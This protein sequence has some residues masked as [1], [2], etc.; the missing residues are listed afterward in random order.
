MKTGER[1]TPIPDFIMRRRDLTHGAKCLWG[2]LDR[3]AQKNGKCY[4]SLPTLATELGTSIDSV[5]RFIVQL[6]NAGLIRVAKA[7]LGR[8]NSTN[9]VLCDTPER[10]AETPPF[11][12]PGKGGRN[13]TFSRSEK[14][15]KSAT[16]K[17]ARVRLEKVANSPSKETIVGRK[18]QEKRQVEPNVKTNGNYQATVADAEALR[19]LMFEHTRKTETVETA[20][21]WLRPARRADGWADVK[22]QLRSKLTSHKPRSNAWFRTVL[23][24]EFGLSPDDRAS[25]IL[26]FTQR[27]REAVKLKD[28]Q[29]RNLEAQRCI[30]EA[31]AHGITHTALGFRW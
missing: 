24:N 11:E 23:A 8:G 31:Q 26:G 29:E 21:S 19:R 25:Q 6:K 15:S 4:P 1:F 7:G 2:R 14:G 20:L 13:T 5:R 10:V 22:Q 9:Y 30:E 3:Y 12:E 28:P 16:E 17:V 18:K 27:Y